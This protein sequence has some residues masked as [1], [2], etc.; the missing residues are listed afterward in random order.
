MAIDAL[1][2]L[3]QS[4]GGRRQA[5]GKAVAAEP[6]IHLEPDRPKLSTAQLRN[7][8]NFLRSLHE[9]F[10]NKA[11]FPSISDISSVAPAALQPRPKESRDRYIGRVV[12]LA[13]ILPEKEL[14]AFQLR[15]AE[16]LNG[17]PNNFI[18]QWKKL[19]KE[20]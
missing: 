14:E 5:S 12:D 13:T 2:Q 15:L 19:I 1:M 3:H 20:M 17:S 10:A 9:I 18:G 8:G 4:N 6:V 7:R 16:K 11:M